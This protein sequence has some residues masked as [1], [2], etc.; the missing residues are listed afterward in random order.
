M[1]HPRTY[2]YV[3]IHIT[4][5]LISALIGIRGW[6]GGD[7]AKAPRTRI[8]VEERLEQLVGPALLPFLVVALGGHVNSLVSMSR[9]GPVA[10]VR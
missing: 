5:R 10:S 1:P 9:E 8:S 4:K 7:P 2:D 3:D 6:L